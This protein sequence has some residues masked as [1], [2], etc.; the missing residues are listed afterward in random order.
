MTDRKRDRDEEGRPKNQRPR[1]SLGR[2][3]PRGE[4]GDPSL[5]VEPE[6]TP[7]ELM[8]QGV[9]HFNRGNYFQ[10]H[11][12]WETA[13]HDSAED[14]RD[15]WQGITQIAVGL[16][17]RG[18]GNLHGAKTLLERGIGRASKYGDVHLDLEVGAL[19]AQAREILAKIEAEGLEAEI[20]TPRA[21]MRPR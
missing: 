4:Q 19:V 11:E 6:G 14:D 13:W 12:A 5:Q 16:T 18:R 7:A 3:L 8:A 15:F 9:E 2:P 21:A 10:A 1:D 17:H 20:G